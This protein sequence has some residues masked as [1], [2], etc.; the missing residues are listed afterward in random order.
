M[1]EKPDSCNGECAAFARLEE[2]S[3][4]TDKELIIMWRKISKLA[5]AIDMGKSWIIGIMVTLCLNLIA[6]VG[7]LVMVIIHSSPK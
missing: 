2:R 4:G 1:V 7:T 5:D 6:G 3:I